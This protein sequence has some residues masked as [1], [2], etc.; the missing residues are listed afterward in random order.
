MGQMRDAFGQKERERERAS[1]FPLVQSTPLHEYVTA[2]L[3]H[4]SWLRSVYSSRW[5]TDKIISLNDNNDVIIAGVLME[6]IFYGKLLDW[7]QDTTPN[8]LVITPI[9]SLP[10]TTWWFEWQGIRNDIFRCC[11]SQP[12][13]TYFALQPYYLM[14]GQQS[15]RIF[16]ILMRVDFDTCLPFACI[17]CPNPEPITRVWC[18]VVCNE[19]PHSSSTNVPQSGSWLCSLWWKRRQDESILPAREESTGFIIDTLPSVSLH[20][21]CGP[22]SRSARC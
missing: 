22:R 4:L 12:N 10:G 2:R 16:E 7:F 3:E 21:V 6:W 18:G 1:S 19:A 20:I 5:N 11:C 8:S 9:T 13:L 14:A 15:W 17:I